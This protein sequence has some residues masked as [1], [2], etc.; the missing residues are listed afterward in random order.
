MT[1]DEALQ[2][3]IDKLWKAIWFFFFFSVGIFLLDFV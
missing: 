1:K 2:K 3:Q